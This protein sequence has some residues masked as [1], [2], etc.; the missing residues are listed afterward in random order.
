[1]G[2]AALPVGRGRS[3]R[4]PDTRPYACSRRPR[5]REH[6]FEARER[7]AF[8]M[9]RGWPRAFMTARSLLGPRACASALAAASIDMREYDPSSGP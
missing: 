4:S 9:S 6:P 5:G 8:R 3:A 7:K 2:D 1:M